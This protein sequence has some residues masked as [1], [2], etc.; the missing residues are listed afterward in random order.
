MKMEN[1]A[2]EKED[3]SASSSGA[4]RTLSAFALALLAVSSI[5]FRRRAGRWAGSG[6]R[7]G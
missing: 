4:E 7:R 2:L 1:V 5:G 3:M 6:G